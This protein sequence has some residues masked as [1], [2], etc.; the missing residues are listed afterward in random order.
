MMM[1][2]CRGQGRSLLALQRQGWLF[3]RVSATGC[4]FAPVLATN[5]VAIRSDVLIT[6]VSLSFE[7]DVL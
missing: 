1:C 5:F 3:G 4:L 7:A 6:K 2:S